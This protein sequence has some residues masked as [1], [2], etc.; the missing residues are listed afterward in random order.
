MPVLVGPRIARTGASERGAIITNVAAH[1]RK[2]KVP[3]TGGFRAVLTLSGRLGAGVDCKTAFRAGFWPPIGQRPRASGRLQARRVEGRGRCRVAVQR[4][5]LGVASGAVRD[6]HRRAAPMACAGDRAAVR[7]RID[8][9][10]DDRDRRGRAGRFRPEAG[11]SGQDCGR[12]AGRAGPDGA[13][14]DTRARRRRALL[15]AARGRRLAPGRRAISRRRWRPRS[16][17]AKSAP[18]TRSTWS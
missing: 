17:S 6:P 16:T 5:R 13:V 3:S 12:E 15:V 7:R 9:D 11:D 4:G 2:R 14:A 18:A 8:G 10:A 1:A